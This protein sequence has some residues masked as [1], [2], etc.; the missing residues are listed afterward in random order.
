MKRILLTTFVLVMAFTG[1][2]KSSAA[3]VFGPEDFLDVSVYNSYTK[4]RLAGERGWVWK[5]SED[6]LQYWGNGQADAWIVSTPFTLRKGQLYEFSC[7]TLNQGG[8]TE[9]DWKTIKFYVTKGREMADFQGKNEI[10]NNPI[11]TY[12]VERNDVLSYPKAT[13]AV[14]EDGEY[15]LALRCVGDNYNTNSVLVD[16]LQIDESTELIP[17]AATAVMATPKANGALGADIEWVNPTKS[18]S[19]DALA[20]IDKVTV[21]CGDREVTVI[22]NP[23]TGEKQT[24]SDNGVSDPGIYSY[25]VVVTCG[26]SSSAP[27]STGEVWIGPDTPSTPTNVAIAP[28]AAKTGYQ[29]TFAHDGLG[30]H[31]GYI[32]SSAIVYDIRLTPGDIQVASGV[33][34]KSYEWI[35][36]SELD[37]DLYSVA[38]TARCGEMLSET[39]VSTPSLFGDALSLPYEPNCNDAQFFRLWSVTGRTPWNYNGGQ[40]KIYAP[41]NCDGWAFT[42]PFKAELPGEYRVMFRPYNYSASFPNTLEAVLSLGTDPASQSNVSILNKTYETP[43]AN[44]VTGVVTYEMDTVKIVVDQAGVYRV[45]FHATNPTAMLGFGMSDLKVEFVSSDVTVMPGA[46]TAISVETGTFGEMK[47]VVKVTAPTE[48]SEGKQL[49]SIA[50]IGIRRGE[51]VVK[52]F[53]NPTPGEELTFT[54]TTMPEPG[55][56]KYGAFATVGEY[57]SLP[58][59]ATTEWVGNDVP[60]KPR[61]IT[62]NRYNDA[63]GAYIRISPSNK[64]VHEGY[65]NSSKFT[66]NVRRSDGAEVMKGGED[67]MIFDTFDDSPW[68][69]KSYTV[70]TLFDGRE[71]EAK[72][73]DAVLGGEA[74]PAPLMVA[75]HEGI[76]DLFT[77]AAPSSWTWTGSALNSGAKGN[78]LASQALEL[79]ADS[80]YTVTYATSALEPVFEGI[81][82]KYLGDMEEEAVA[83]EFERGANSTKFSVAESGRY[84]LAVRNAHET[85]ELPLSGMVLTATTTN[86]IDD[87]VTVAP[88]YDAAS[89]MLVLPEGCK[90][91][92]YNSAGIEVGVFG[93]KVSLAALSSGVYIVR[94]S[95]AGNDN[96]VFKIVK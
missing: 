63:T 25:T 24:V 27:A 81:L 15:T 48:D 4:F 33:T 6:A 76:L 59:F 92:V 17:S 66:Y 7:I 1:W 89:G 22:N 67:T 68:G 84:F 36:T 47:V 85:A 96:S 69:K 46:P 53:E 9:A 45:G 95:G 8:M 58:V 79:S 14:E 75:F 35:P 83:V 26:S 10:L 55:I 3:T 28:N 19:G 72:V 57:S 12:R 39:G 91:R 42:P 31:N 80:I 37:Y 23:R 73:S 70:T 88:V 78:W 52:T 90:A 21:M 60:E 82:A 41:T 34:T 87:V 44:P 20:S 49:A 94:I 61:A 2:V 30:A 77:A 40:K 50:S 38:V 56:Y 32:N 65:V 51:D 16:Y 71:S 74:V 43:A 62:V 54:D 64:G 18:V 29:I 13:F 93:N 86:S 11:L 5:Q